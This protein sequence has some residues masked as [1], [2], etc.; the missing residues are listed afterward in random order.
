MVTSRIVGLC[1]LVATMATGCLTEQRYMAPEEGGPWAFAI[2]EDTPAFFE[3][4]D[5]NVYLVEQRVEFEFREPTDR[6]LRELGDIGALQIPYGQLPFLRRDDIEI[7]IDWTL[8]NVSDQTLTTAVLVNGF[9]EF[10]EYDPGV[11][12]IDN[13]VVA[14][15]SGWERNIRLEPGERATGTVRQEQLDEIAVDLAT[16]VNGAPNANQVVYFENNSATDPRSQMFIP[17]VIPALTGVRLGLRSDAAVP[18]VLEAT[19]RI[20]DNRGVLVQ[21]DAD[22]WPLP[23]P[24]LFGPLDAAAAA[25]PAPAP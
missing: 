16:V 24:A 23:A 13:E 1:A 22:P 6:E 12:I 3:S 19:V 4:E 2:D 7:Q 14:D 15:F 5:G 17:D 11:Q 21:G 20:R 8:S 18:V 25:A 10:H 9:N